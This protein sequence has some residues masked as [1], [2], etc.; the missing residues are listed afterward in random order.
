MRRLHAGIV[1]GAGA[2]IV[3]ALLTTGFAQDD[4]NEPTTEARVTRLE[5]ELASL[6]TRFEARTTPRADTGEGAARGITL[7]TRITALE[8]RVAELSTDLTRVE[9]QAAAALRRADQ[10]GRDAKAAEQVAR[11]AGLRNR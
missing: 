9:R 1:V 7:D 3:G 5:R 11:E 6:E 2:M 4:E 10:A 8:R